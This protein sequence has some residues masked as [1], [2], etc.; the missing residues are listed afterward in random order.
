MSNR[1]ARSVLPGRLLRRCDQ[2]DDLLHSGPVK[3]LAGIH[4]RGD[5]EFSQSLLILVESHQAGGERI[6]IL[7]AG[8][9]P[10]SFAKFLLSL[11]QLW[12]IYERGAEIAVHQAGFRVE[13]NCLVQDVYSFL[14]PSRKQESLP[15]DAVLR[16]SRGIGGDSGLQLANGGG[17]VALRHVGA[18]QA[19]VTAFPLRI[20]TIEILELRDSAIEVFLVAKRISQVVADAGFLR[21]EALGHAVFG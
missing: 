10:E 17:V 16:R 9:E 5:F 11:G 18:S 8:L 19:V 13:R 2:A 1:R 14:V 4:P 7:G 21:V 6:V 12:S 20:L 3:I 15:Q